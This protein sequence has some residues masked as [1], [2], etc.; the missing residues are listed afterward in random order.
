MFTLDQ[1]KEAH[2]KVKSGAD[3]PQYIKDLLL[4]GVYRYTIYVYDGHAEYTGKEN[5]SINSEAEYPF[6]HISDEIKSDEFKSHLKAH[7]QGKTDYFT[8]CR[9]SS[10]T[11]VDKWTVDICNKIC[12][13][14]D[15]SGTFVFK[16]KIPI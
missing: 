15:K 6:L 2:S 7:Q 14:Y 16:E 12:T 8:F 4:L 3:F 11:G 10:K 9:D 13:Y 5:Y 1:I